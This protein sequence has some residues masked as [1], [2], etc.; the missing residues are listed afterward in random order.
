MTTLAFKLRALFI[1]FG[2]RNLAEL[3]QAFW[4]LSCEVDRVEWER[5]ECPLD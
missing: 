4:H 5:R 2:A 3:R 1:V